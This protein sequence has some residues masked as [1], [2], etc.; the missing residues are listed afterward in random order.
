MTFVWRGIKYTTQA[1]NGIYIFQAWFGL[2]YNSCF[3]ILKSHF[4]VG[5]EN[6]SGLM[7]M[8]HHWLVCITLKLFQVVVL[9]LFA[10]GG[11][12]YFKGNN[13]NGSFEKSSFLFCFVF[14]FFYLNKPE[15]LEI[16]GWLRHYGSK[17]V[18]I[19]VMRQCM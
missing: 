10:I 5:D 16:F 12:I 7:I 2:N 11:W 8:K 4:S 3:P 18:H 13:M 9:P 19:L 1:S 6:Y 14:S 17:N 15:K